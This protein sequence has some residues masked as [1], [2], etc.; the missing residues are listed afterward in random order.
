VRSCTGQRAHIGD[1]KRS[2]VTLRGLA[3]SNSDGALRSSFALWRRHNI[4]ALWGLGIEPYPLIT[5]AWT[6]VKDS[7][8][9]RGTISVT[10]VMLGEIRAFRLVPR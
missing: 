9:I 2:T 4:P 6:C 7:L 8:V 3:P 1:E 10:V 5:R